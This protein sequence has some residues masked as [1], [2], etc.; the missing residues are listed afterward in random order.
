M[1]WRSNDSIIGD[2]VPNEVDVQGAV[3]VRL[4]LAQRSPGPA[5]TTGDLSTR[6]R[7]CDRRLEAAVELLR[8]EPLGLRGLASD[9]LA[10]S[11]LRPS[12]SMIVRIA[13]SSQPLNLPV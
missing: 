12:T 2:R 9:A 11:A 6:I 7:G 10:S 1:W 4:G 5:R 13:P 3:E 8:G